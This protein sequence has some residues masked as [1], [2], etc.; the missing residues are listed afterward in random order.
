ML[1]LNV[2][3]PRTP[4]KSGLLAID[5]FGTFSIL[6]VVLML[7]LGLDFG[8]AS[9][10]WSSATVICLIVFGALMIAAFVYSEKRLARYPLIPTAMFSNKSIVA[11]FAVTFCQGM[12]FIGGEYYLPLFFQ[13][14]KGA[15]PL[16]SGLYLIPLSITEAIMGCVSGIIIHQTGRYRELIWLGTF[17]LTVGYGLFILFRTETP[18]GEVTGLAIVG[19]IGAGLLFQPPLVAVQAMVSQAD[20]ATATATL[21]FARN[22]ATSLSVVL[23]GII[24][25]NGMDL[26]IPSL[27]AAGL[28]STLIASFSHGKAAASVEIIKT[29]SNDVQRNAVKD[30]YSWS[31]RNLWIT[32]TVVAGIGFGLSVF[33]KHQDL[34]NEH[35]E[36]R[37]GVEEMTDRK[38]KA[39][40]EVVQA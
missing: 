11:A 12:V 4:L 9:F 8:G 37:T 7:L 25:Q 31:L 36:T 15:G 5:W 17:L 13:S 19:G 18:I 10:P 26:R 35:T 21:G 27:R 40:N 6:G 14:V 22:I 1:F 38:G 2:H 3:N 32:Y 16:K 20:T 29:I 30:A 23:G 28:N 33:I 39:P 24:F 34:S